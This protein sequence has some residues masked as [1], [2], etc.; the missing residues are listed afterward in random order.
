[1]I[2]NLKLLANSLK[3]Y[4]ST[5]SQKPD[6]IICVHT[7]HTVPK[8]LWYHTMKWRG[9]ACNEMEKENAKVIAKIFM[10]TYI[11]LVSAIRFK[12]QLK[13]DS[14]DLMKCGDI[15]ITYWPRV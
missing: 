11:S 2:T 10:L 12:F 15:Y 13:F 14:L 3:S 7:T 1:M 6:Q 5:T 8:Q 9:L 4:M